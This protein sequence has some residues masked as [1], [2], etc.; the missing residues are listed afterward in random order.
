MTHKIERSSTGNEKPPS[1]GDWAMRNGKWATLHLDTLAKRS[2]DK[3]MQRVRL[4]IEAMAASSTVTEACC[5][6]HALVEYR[7]M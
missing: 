1:G 4:P 3:Q 2:L 5:V 6:C 7:V